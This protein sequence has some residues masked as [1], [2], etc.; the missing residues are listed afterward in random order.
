[1]C[2]IVRAVADTT[3]EAVGPT[4]FSSF[5]A[6]SIACAAYRCRDRRDRYVDAIISHGF[7]TAALAASAVTEARAGSTP[8]RKSARAARAP[9]AGRSKP[10]LSR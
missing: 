3:I 7:S 1:V 10:S 4:D 8:S 2:G 5:I 6:T 9:K